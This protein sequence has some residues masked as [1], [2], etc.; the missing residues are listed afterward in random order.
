M[1]IKS[2]LIWI[3]ALLILV[4]IIIAFGR[5]VLKNK[6]LVGSGEEQYAVCAA[7]V[8]ECPDGSYVSR[9]PPSCEFAACPGSN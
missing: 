1:N 6:D 8:R 3:A 2:S 7:D 5:L 9:V 4:A